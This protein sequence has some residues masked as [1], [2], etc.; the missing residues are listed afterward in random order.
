LL[1]WML[2]PASHVNY[3]WKQENI[4][5]SAVCVSFT[6]I[7]YISSPYQLNL[8]KKKDFCWSVQVQIKVKCAMLYS[9]E[10]STELE[11]LLE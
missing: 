1:W 4:W 5:Q 3:L 10:A 8:L 9:N 11:R 7:N 2:P 6:G